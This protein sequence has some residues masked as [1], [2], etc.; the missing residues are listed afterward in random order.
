MRRALVASVAVLLAFPAAARA[1]HVSVALH[2]SARLGDRLSDNT[3]RGGR[4]LEH[5]LHRPGA[6]PGELHRQPL[7]R[8]VRHGRL[9]VRRRHLQRL[10][11]RHLPRRAPR[12]AAHHD[13]EDPGRLLR[14]AVLGTTGRGPTARPA[15]PCASRPRATR[16]GTA[17]S[18]RGLRR[19][20][21]EAARPRRRAGAARW[22]SSA[23]PPPT[24]SW[25]RPRATASSAWP[26]TTSCGASTATTV[27][28]AGRAST[29]SAAARGT[30]GW[31]EAPRRTAWTA[32]AATTG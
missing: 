21:A 31:R 22:R 27:S 20:P 30:I 4:R 3:W 14:H 25:G 19:R 2:V 9:C 1:D 32:T 23:R 13:L 11:Q 8:R 15:T 29:A 24:R 10:G 17:S 28:L 7:P 16:T 18:T 5:R 12:A 6:R 26:A